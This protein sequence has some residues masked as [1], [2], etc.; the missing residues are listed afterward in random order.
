MNVYTYHFWQAYRRLKKRVESV[1]LI[2][3]G[4]SRLVALVF[5]TSTPDRAQV[6][7]HCL[8]CQAELCHELAAHCRVE[9]N[10]GAVDWQP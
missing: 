6:Y 9:L 2:A 5:V 7:A 8:E 1:G 10:I 4:S 3:A